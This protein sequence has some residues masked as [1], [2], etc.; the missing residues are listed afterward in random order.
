MIYEALHP[1]RELCV[2]LNKT[3]PKASKQKFYHSYD[4]LL[5]LTHKI[6][7]KS[8]SRRDSNDF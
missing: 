7:R 2:R 8:F 5:S 1:R 4:F 6:S 3:E